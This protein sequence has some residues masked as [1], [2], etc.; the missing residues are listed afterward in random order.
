MKQCEPKN[1]EKDIV[2][3]MAKIKGQAVRNRIKIAEFMRGY[4]T[5]KERVIKEADFRRSLD[6]ANIHLTP[7]E[8]DTLCHV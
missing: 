6:T 2:I 4:D 5:H 7:T 8:A 1:T 3:V